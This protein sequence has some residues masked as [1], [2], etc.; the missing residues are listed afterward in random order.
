MAKGHQGSGRIQK[1]QA[2]KG[3]NRGVGGSG[4]SYSEK[5]DREINERFKRIKINAAEKREVISQI[6]ANVLRKALGSNPLTDEEKKILAGIY[7][8]GVQL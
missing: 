7:A 2:K 8:K 3:W 4:E 6:E 5:Q 1:A